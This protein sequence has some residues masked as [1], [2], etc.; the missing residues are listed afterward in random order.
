MLNAHFK[1]NY[2]LCN[3]ATILYLLRWKMNKV[4]NKNQR[5]LISKMAVA[6]DYFQ[7]QQMWFYAQE[8]YLK[9]I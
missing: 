7:S 8:T 4:I 5:N 1:G 9:N 3:I 2:I 6:S